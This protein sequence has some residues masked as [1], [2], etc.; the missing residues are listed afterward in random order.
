V[1]EDCFR[2]TGNAPRRGPCWPEI[3]QVNEFDGKFDSQIDTSCMLCLRVTLSW[4][5]CRDREENGTT[6]TTSKQG[7]HHSWT[8]DI[9]G[10]LSTDANP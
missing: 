5:G 3:R 9:A 1:D 10:Y 8:H 6:T 4:L 2:W 7:R